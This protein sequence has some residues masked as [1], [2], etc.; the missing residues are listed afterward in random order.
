[1]NCNQWKMAGIVSKE[2]ESTRKYT[3][4]LNTKNKED[5]KVVLIGKRE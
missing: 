1:M 5:Q 3:D 4:L 2:G